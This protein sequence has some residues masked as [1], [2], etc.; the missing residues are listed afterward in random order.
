MS[1]L[2]RT[3]ELDVDQYMSQDFLDG[4]P[5]HKETDVSEQFMESAHVF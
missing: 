3:D 1:T 2:G 4:F 5:L